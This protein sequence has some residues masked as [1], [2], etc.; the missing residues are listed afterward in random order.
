MKLQPG[1]SLYIGE[2][3]HFIWFGGHPWETLNE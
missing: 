2:N 1:G 3:Q